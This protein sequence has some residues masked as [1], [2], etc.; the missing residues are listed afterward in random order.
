MPSTLS[1]G[2]LASR[3]HQTRAEAFLEDLQQRIYESLGLS[4]ED[5]QQREW[6]GQQLVVPARLQ[7]M[8]LQLT[9]AEFDRYRD[10]LLDGLARDEEARRPTRFERP[11]QYSILRELQQAVERAAAR[12]SFDVPTRPVLGTLPTRLLEPLMLPVPGTAEVV[13][14]VDGSLLTYAHQLAKAV[15]QAL[16]QELTETEAP[17]RGAAQDWGDLD[18]AGAGRE[19]FLQ[20]MTACLDGNPASTPS[21]LPDPEWET[22]AADLCDAMELFLVA[23]EYAKLIQGDHLQ[24]RPERRSAHGQPF[25]ALVWTGEQE[26][27]AD[28]MGLALMLAAATE[29]GASLAWAFWSADVLLASFAVFER[30]A[31]L[32]ASSPG[33]A[34]A[35]APTAHDE[36]RRYLRELMLQ[37]HD[38]EQAVAFAES[39]QPVV[40]LL[41]AHLTSV[42]VDERL[43]P[44]QVH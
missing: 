42:L 32:V 33:A 38:G 11:H 14:V 40:D 17:P 8:A 9:P 16:P 37:W 25:D 12:L 3:H 1:D 44:A 30:A 19:R 39:L 36:R 24:A 41:E 35:A 23:R 4:A 22:V 15:A 31:W 5:C 18:P 26:L 28:W 27:K 43:G 6:M 10:A 21:Y 13:L 20:L 7:Q 29:R 34:V 2:L